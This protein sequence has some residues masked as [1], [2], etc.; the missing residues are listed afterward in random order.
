MRPSRC[1]GWTSSIVL[2]WWQCPSALMGTSPKPIQTLSH[3]LLH[4]SVSPCDAFA[5]HSPSARR[6]PTKLP[7]PFVHVETNAGALG[8]VVLQPL[9]HL[10]FFLPTLILR[11]VG[12]CCVSQP[13]FAETWAPL[14]SCNILFELIVVVLPVAIFH[15]IRED[16]L[17]QI[18][19]S[20]GRMTSSKT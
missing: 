11:S 16:M 1:F 9:P 20:P 18:P 7:I 17:L 2:P 19:F 3:A 10:G 15:L 12:P 4:P 13:W 14:P 5:C 8:F 6:F